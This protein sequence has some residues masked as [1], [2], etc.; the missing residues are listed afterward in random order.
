ML[1]TK[2]GKTQARHPAIFHASCGTEN[3]NLPS[4]RL[5]SVLVAGKI[6]GVIYTKC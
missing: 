1:L 6:F 2:R 5:F 4:R 3:T